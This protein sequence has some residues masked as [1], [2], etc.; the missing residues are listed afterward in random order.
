MT[1]RGSCWLTVGLLASGS[2][3]LLEMASVL[4]PAVGLADDTALIMGY[5]ETPNPLPSYVTEVMSLFVSPSTPQFDGQPTYEGYPPLVVPTEEG[6]DYQQAMTL[7]FR[8]VG[9]G[10][11]DGT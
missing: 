8:S 2:A 6:A 7:G 10:D 4:N 11:Q 3:G 1:R 9:R 5:T